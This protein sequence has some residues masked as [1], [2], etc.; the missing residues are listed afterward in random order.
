VLA[1]ALLAASPPAVA[2][3][4]RDLLPEAAILAADGLSRDGQRLV[5]VERG[6]GD[7]WALLAF[8]RTAQG[9][10][11]RARASGPADGCSPVVAAAAE[12]GTALVYSY[13][14]GVGRVYGVGSGGLTATGTLRVE[15]ERSYANPPPGGAA[16]SPDGAFALLGAPS[17]GCKITVP[18][19]RCG[20]AVL[21]QANTGTW[22][23]AAR[24]EFPEGGPFNV[25]FGR[26]VALSTGAQVVAIG[27]PGHV[28]DQGEVYLFEKREGWTEVGVLVPDARS[29]SIFGTA[30]AMTGDGRTVAVGADRAAYVFSRDAQGWALT[31]RIDTPE[32]AAGSFGSAVAFS[33]DGRRLLIGAP[34]TGCADLPRCGAAYAFERPPRGGAWRLLGKLTAPAPRP[35][36]D[37]GW[38]LALD[39]N[40]RTAAVQADRPYVLAVP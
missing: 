9:W 29:D 5:A 36:I 3:A 18:Q 15:A 4:G 2:Q 11:E 6:P 33:G 17:Y 12:N 21:F 26:A 39:G 13:Q 16:L 38:K 14:Q 1:L 37:F 34:R 25:D 7:C 35:F 30:V 23:E 22:R 8:M 27:G 20:L 28:G 40:G 32:E 24:L 10:A 19:Q 31:A